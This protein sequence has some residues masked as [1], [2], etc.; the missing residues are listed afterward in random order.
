MGFSSLMQAKGIPGESTKKCAQHPPS[1]RCN[2][3]HSPFPA[4]S[5]LHQ[6]PLC[7]AP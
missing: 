6:H 4:A 3:T 1:V 7:E 5:A 2:G